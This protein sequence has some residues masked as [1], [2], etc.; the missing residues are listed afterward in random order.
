MQPNPGQ[1]KG[2]TE[3]RPSEEKVEFRSFWF[4]WVGVI[5]LIPVDFITSISSKIIRKR[6]FKTR[7]LKSE[8]LSCYVFS[9]MFISC[10]FIVAAIADITLTIYIH[11][12]AKVWIDSQILS[13]LVCSGV[14]KIESVVRKSAGWNIGENAVPSGGI[15]RPSFVASVLFEICVFL[16][17]TTVLREVYMIKISF[18]SRLL[19]Y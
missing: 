5:I 7:A 6:C 1:D 2:Q 13:N 8:R 14:G 15:W 3:R 19:Y 12:R 18:T 11:L 16:S 4:V 17:M 9:I 10:E